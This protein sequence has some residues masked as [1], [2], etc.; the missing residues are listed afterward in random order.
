M[1]TLFEII[2]PVASL[3][4]TFFEVSC[5]AKEEIQEEAST[6][7]ETPK[8]NLNVFAKWISTLISIQKL[9]K[10]SESSDPSFN[11]GHGRASTFEP[12]ATAST[13]QSDSYLQYLVYSRFVYPRLWCPGEPPPFLRNNQ[14]N[15]Q[16]HFLKL[17][18]TNP[19]TLLWQHWSPS[20]AASSG[21]CT[22]PERRSAIY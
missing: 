9:F 15:F 3:H 14:N 12:T 2:L 13:R 7:L 16:R 5:R 20:R 17:Y 21:F 18:R 4:G 11:D 1:K 10:S 6:I 8:S 22:H 19:C